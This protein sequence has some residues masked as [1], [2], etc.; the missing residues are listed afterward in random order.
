MGV[1]C[2][3]GEPDETD[4]RAG[5]VVA[6]PMARSGAGADLD[7]HSIWVRGVEPVL[8]AGGEGSVPSGT[9]RHRYLTDWSAL[10][11]LAC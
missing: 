6:A 1:L 4:S 8:S 2:L 11:L 3:I 10:R 5:G 7:R 9:C